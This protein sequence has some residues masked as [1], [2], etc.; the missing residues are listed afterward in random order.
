M[1]IVH[2]VQATKIGASVFHFKTA[3]RCSS[4]REH[5]ECFGSAKVEN[6]EDEVTKP[7]VS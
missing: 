4:T 6:K 1:R 2:K 7:W 5:L 3:T